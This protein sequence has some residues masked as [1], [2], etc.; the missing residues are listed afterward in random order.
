MSL[1]QTSDRCAVFGARGMAAVPFPGVNRRVTTINSAQSPGFDLL[2]CPVTMTV[3][4][5]P[6]VVV[7]AAG[8][9]GG[10]QANNTIPRIFTGQSHD[11]TM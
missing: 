11:S 9:V 10:I 6:D 7:L 3:Q 4:Q 1:L 2:D 5:R 8:K